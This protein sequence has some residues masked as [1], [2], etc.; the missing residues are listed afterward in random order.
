MSD[1]AV[2]AQTGPYQV[3]VTEGETNE[4]PMRDGSH[5]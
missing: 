5:N 2:D 3:E 1:E 4:R